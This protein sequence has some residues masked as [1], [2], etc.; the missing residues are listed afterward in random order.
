[1][2]IGEDGQAHGA[3]AVVH[4]RGQQRLAIGARVKIQVMLKQLQV[5]V[6]KLQG[7]RLQQRRGRVLAGLD[8]VEVITC[9]METPRQGQGAD[10]R[11]QQ[12]RAGEQGGFAEGLNPL[13]QFVE[14][15]LG[16]PGRTAALQQAAEQRLI[17]TAL[18][19]L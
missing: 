8:A 5:E 16:N 14:L 19:M 7:Q 17:T 2:V 4:A 18:G 10:Q 11:H 15:A 1:M 3:N 9:L 12:V 6:Q 13:E